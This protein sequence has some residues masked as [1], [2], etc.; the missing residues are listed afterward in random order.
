M[1]REKSI[2]SGGE[3]SP[4]RINFYQRLASIQGGP[5]LE[6]IR[7][8]PTS[9]HYFRWFKAYKNFLLSHCDHLHLM[10]FKG[11]LSD[12][13]IFALLIQLWK[14][15]TNHLLNKWSHFERAKPIF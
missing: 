13:L 14:I 3:Y 15:N 2:I 7:Y 8:L 12:C 5:L 11:D 4:I 1:R 6:Q 10:P 9:N